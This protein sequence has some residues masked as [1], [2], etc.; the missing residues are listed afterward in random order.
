M[1]SKQCLVSLLTCR[2]QAGYRQEQ[3]KPAPRLSEMPRAESGLTKVACG[4]CVLS[5]DFC[6]WCTGLRWAN[7]AQAGTWPRTQLVDA[8]PRCA[9]LAQRGQA[10]LVE[11]H[12]VALRLA[13][14]CQHLRRQ[15]AGRV[16]RRDRGAAAPRLLCS[17]HLAKNSQQVSE[18]SVSSAV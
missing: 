4:N 10:A 14:H 3:Q 18:W 16:G 15:L 7:A 17:A 12:D 8:L 6:T 11:L 2:M 9:Q 13:E 1:V 5:T